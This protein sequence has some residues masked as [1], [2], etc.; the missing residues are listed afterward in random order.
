MDKYN[1]N[2]ALNVQLGQ[3]GYDIIGSGGTIN[4]TSNPGVT[5]VAITVLTGSTDDGMNST[6]SITATSVDTDVWDSLSTVAVPTGT[7]IYGRW[8]VV[9]TASSDIAIAYR[10]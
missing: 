7:T 4:Q 9:T 1:A 2:E 6:G 3:A 5:W 8:S 10:G